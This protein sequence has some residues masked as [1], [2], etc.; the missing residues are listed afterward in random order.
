[1]SNKTWCLIVLAI[2]F[3]LSQVLA[4]TAVA[5]PLFAGPS[6]DNFAAA[7]EIVGA[8]GSVN[9]DN[10]GATKEYW[11]NWHAG[12]SG[13]ASVW[14]RWIAAAN[15]D[16]VF[17]TAG[18][19]LDTLLAV[20][21]WPNQ[22]GSLLTMDSN[23]DANS[24]TRTSRVMFNAVANTRYYIAIDGYNG[25]TGRIILNWTTT[26]AAP[27]TGRVRAPAAGPANDNLTNAQDITGG[28]GSVTDSNENATKESWEGAHAGNAGGVSVWYRWVAP[29]NGN[30]TFDTNGSDLDTLLAVY[31]WPN[32][33]GNLI[34][35][36]SNDDAG[37]ST[38]TSRVTLNAMANVEYFIAIDGYNGRTGHLVLN[39]GMDRTPQLTTVDLA[40]T[41]LYPDHMPQGRVFTRITNNGPAILSNFDVQLRCR[42]LLNLRPGIRAPGDPINVEK[43]VGVTLR[44]GQ[45]GIYDTG[46]AIDTD[47]FTYRVTCSVSGQFTDSN[48]SNNTYSENIP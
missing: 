40:V 12:N 47:V 45:T 46:I 10:V 23:D 21:T 14:Y 22:S 26:N 13:G 16:V 44:P 8:T 41:D 15:G 32:R 43:T 3:V 24:G 19:D 30:V 2:V 38:R 5:A 7:F 39:W 28:S 25:G 36:G 33:S 35:R 9:G 4:Q 17:D 18:S 20:Y 48:P 6:N 1:M 42:A 27:S 31:S 11:E 29:A 37:S 34:E